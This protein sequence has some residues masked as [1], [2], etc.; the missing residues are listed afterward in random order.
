M[1]NLASPRFLA[2][3]YLSVFLISVISMGWVSGW[4]VLVIFG[5][6]FLFP[7]LS[8][9]Y[10]RYVGVTI[11]ALAWAATFYFWPSGNEGLFWQNLTILMSAGGVF[12]LLA[13]MLILGAG[14]L[15]LGNSLW[16]SLV[17][18]FSEITNRA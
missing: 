2:A 9:G 10:K 1:T 16:N 18:T 5:L 12:L 6:I 3:F 4:P 17:Q 11:L 15:E 8:S 14:L 7:I 13:L